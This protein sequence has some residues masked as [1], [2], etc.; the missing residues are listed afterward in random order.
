MLFNS[1][2]FIFL[3]LPATLATFYLLSARGPRRY[4]WVVLVAAAAVFYGLG[5]A[6]HLPL[7]IV[8]VLMNYLVAARIS[9][10]VERKQGRGW[11]A[12]GVSAN[13]AVL[14]YFKYAPL[15]A[16]TAGEHSIV[17]SDLSLPVGISFY[18]FTQIAYLVDLYRRT[19][20]RYRLGEYATFVSYF[21]HLVAGP[22]LH[23]TDV[24]PQLASPAL[25]LVNQRMILTGV[26]LFALGLAKKV[27]IADQ[28]APT[29]D[30]AFYAASIGTSLSLGEAWL[31][32]VAYA[33]QIYF[34]FSGYSDMARGISRMFG[35]ELPINFD[36]PYRVTSL[37]D[38]WRRWH[39]TLSRF[40]RIY[41]Y[42]PLGGS[43]KG[44]ART[45]VNLFITM[46]LGGLWHG[47]GFGF[48]AWGAFHGICLALNHQFRVVR[49][50]SGAAPREGSIP[51]LAGW[52][53]TMLVVM[54]G[55]ALFR[56]PTF[57]AAGLVLRGLLGLNGADLP[58]AISGLGNWLP[59][60]VRFDGMF[61]HG[62]FA[63][64]F[65]SCFLVAVFGAIALQPLNTN[66]LIMVLENSSESGRV[67]RWKY[68]LVA[69]A[70]AA[71]ALALA[72]LGRNSPFL[73]YQF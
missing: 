13:L 26:V 66:R 48:L 47:A 29:A 11:L 45:A 46:T 39:M 51:R 64:P 44:R 59:S 2:A 54:V 60:T 14:A 10:A 17:V 32:V 61:F 42:V 20:P 28:I 68:A 43:R 35:M 67:D 27:L 16:A 70:G 34:D 8:S 12:L 30:S 37:I 65:L 9:V 40:L 5:A 63:S 69:M 19:A 55:W 1:A 33:L 38:F 3:F 18:T 24:L 71:F 36:S 22:V 57:D 41:L 56:A 73:Y 6:R 7:L 21:P 62:F 23:H 31:G 52:A 15:I 49:A 25:G 50:R 58:T 72:G 53:L 4:L